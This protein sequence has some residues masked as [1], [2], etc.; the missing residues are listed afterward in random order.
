[1]LSRDPLEFSSSLASFVVT[2]HALDDTLLQ[3]ATLATRDVPGCDL[4]GITLLR[5]GRPV[6]AVFTDPSAPEIDTAEYDTG[7]GPCLDG[8]VT[9]GSSESR[10]HTSRPAGRSSRPPPRRPAFGAPCRCRWSS[11]APASAR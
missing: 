11:A 3:V 1:M 5:D 4:A 7:K 6:T 8:S 10:T 2:D 9:V